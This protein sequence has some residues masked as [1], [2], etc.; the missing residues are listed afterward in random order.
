MSVLSRILIGIGVMLACACFITP[1]SAWELSMGGELTWR[2]QAFGQTGPMGFFGPANVDQGAGDVQLFTGRLVDNDWSAR[3]G[4]FASFNAWLGSQ[5]GGLVTGSQASRQT[6]FMKLNPVFR[7]NRALSVNGQLY[8]GSYGDQVVSDAD[9]IYG[10]F[11]NRTF[12]LPAPVNSQYLAGERPGVQQAF[13]PIYVNMLWA[14]V[15]LPVGVLSFG[16]RSFQFGTGLMIDGDNN[17]STESLKL[18]VPLG[19]VQLGLLWYPFRRAAKTYYNPFDDNGKNA[20]DIGALIRYNSGPLSVGVLGHYTRSHIGPEAARV[21]RALDRFSLGADLVTREWTNVEDSDSYYGVAFAKYFNGRIF[22]NTEIDVFKQKTTRNLAQGIQTTDDQYF[23][24]PWPLYVDHWRFMSE[25]GLLAG[26]AKFGLLYAWISGPD[27]RHGIPIDRSGAL[28]VPFLRNVGGIDYYSDYEWLDPLGA[29]RIMPTW[30]LTNTSVF[31]P[32]S[33]IMVYNY[34]LGTDVS[35]HTNE[36][37]VQ[38][39]SCFGARVDYAVASNLNVFSSFFYAQ[40]TTR[41]G[42]T[43]GYLRPS[44]RMDGS[45]D[46]SQRAPLDGNYA[47]NPIPTIP[48]RDLGWEVDAGFSWKLLEGFTVE[49]TAGYWEPGGWFKYACVHRGIRNWGTADRAASTFG[50]FPDRPL[51][52]IWGLQ[53]DCVLD[54]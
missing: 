32:Y 54:F 41:S 51:D 31:R 34:G 35:P 47:D 3:P 12:T 46:R 24:S 1:A 18:V 39:A 26:A 11:F 48:E 15:R 30:R 22:F 14:T 52:P 2:Y 16:K 10:G 50:V 49:S 9:D 25:L 53:I 33:L 4:D 23:L 38:D 6:L 21:M 19:P 37:W 36:G 8:I 13:S 43:W 40:R 7:I 29:Y 28:P 17:T 20:A 27:V 5:V 42:Y 44:L 45:V